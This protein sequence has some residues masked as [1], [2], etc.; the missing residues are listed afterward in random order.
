MVEGEESLNLPLKWKSGADLMSKML[1]SHPKIIN[2]I[3][4]SLVGNASIAFIARLKLY[5]GSASQG[6]SALPSQSWH[7]PLQL[8]R[9]FWAI[10][11]PDKALTPWWRLLHGCI[12]IQQKFHRWN[13]SRWPSAVCRTCDNAEEDIYHFAANC[14]LKQEY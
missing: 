9:V 5:C 8:W 3:V 1:S 4:H 11:I 7:L 12:D 14:T 13:P 2:M 6:T 10:L